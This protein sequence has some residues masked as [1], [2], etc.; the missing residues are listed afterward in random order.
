MTTNLLNRTG[1]VSSLL[2]IFL[3]LGLIGCVDQRHDSANSTDSGLVNPQELELTSENQHFFVP[4]K[5]EVVNLPEGVMPWAATWSPDGNNVLFHDYNHGRGNEW[6]VPVNAD[7]SYG[8]PLCITCQ[9]EDRP[10]LVGVFSYIFPDNRRI[11]IANELGDQAYVMECVSSIL[12]C[13]E[14]SFIPVDLSADE[15]PLMRN[16]GRRT[17]HLS[18]DSNSLAYSMVRPDALIM[19][20]SRLEKLDGGYKAVNHKVI[21]PPSPTGPQDMSQKSRSD[22]GQ[23]YEFKSFADGGKSAIVVGEPTYGNA[24]MLKVDLETGV[25]KKLTGD[26]DWDE[27]GATSPDGRH[28]VVASWRGMNRL[29]SLNTMPLSRPFAVYPMG[30]LIAIYY[31]SSQPGFA[32]DLQPWLLQSEGDRDGKLMGQPLAP[33]RGGDDF[34]GNNLAGLSFW[35]PDSTRVIIQ[36]R[37]FSSVPESSND[38]VKQKG[39][40]PSRVLIARISDKPTEPLGA[41]ST[42]V[43]N[44]AKSP[45]DFFGGFATPG[46]YVIDGDHS[47]NAI[48]TIAGNVAAGQST[49]I[50]NK[51]SND[52]INFLDG[53]ELTQTAVAGRV[54]NLQTQL[55][56]TDE[57]GQQTGF[58][59]TDLSFVRV[60]PDAKVGE[61]PLQKFGSVQAS[62][63]GQSS[64]G[65]PDVGACPKSFPRPSSLEV[66][67]VRQTGNRVTIEVKASVNG[68]T[69]PVNGASVEMDGKAFNTNS[70]GKILLKN[71]G[72][73]RTVAIS[74][75][76]TFLPWSGIIP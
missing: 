52:G 49:V 4:I 44:W 55:T 69:R 8:E 57:N 48:L 66:S 67:S 40:S 35:S 12:S 36:E 23:L 50:Y 29:S 62:F 28:L 47:G 53:T 38:Y 19:M 22:A 1:F 74:A 37:Q 45:Q 27:D 43:G 21:N 64:E 32:C 30:A 26:L 70:S 18:P 25:Y 9:M 42:L 61:P 65:L 75:G 16:L 63:R 60:I 20:V 3:F 2:G 24:D 46:V 17:F 51:F 68:D 7:N 39:M 33:Y 76:D 5:H 58:L 71:V 13:A 6:V 34:T 14:H 73:N 72:P 11:F 54:G 59:H 15:N 31:V 10:N 56:S 41:V